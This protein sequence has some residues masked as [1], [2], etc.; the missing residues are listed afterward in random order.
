M[1]LVLTVQMGRRRSDRSNMGQGEDPQGPEESEDP[2]SPKESED[3]KDPEDSQDPEEEPQTTTRRRRSLII[4][5]SFSS[6]PQPAASVE[7]N[8][9]T[10]PSLNTITDP[11]EEAKSNN[12]LSV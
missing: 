8:Q 3:P 9:D 2:Q 5:L 10:T 6:E 1:V 11:K 7:E 4:P 12:F